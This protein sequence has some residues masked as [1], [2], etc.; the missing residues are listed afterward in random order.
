MKTNNFLLLALLI[1]LT[2]C[3][4]EESNPVSP[5]IT[6]Y[7]LTGHFEN[8][9]LGS[10]YKIIATDFLIL[11]VDSLWDPLHFSESE[12]NSDG[13]FTLH[14]GEITDS[15]RAEYSGYEVTNVNFGLMES[16][17]I[18]IVKDFA[19]R[20]FYLAYQTQIKYFA[21]YGNSPRRI[22]SDTAKAGDFGMGLEF[23]PKDYYINKT[24][25]FTNSSFTRTL[26]YDI[27]LKEGWNKYY[28]KLES[29]SSNSRVIK[30]TGTEPAGGKWYLTPSPN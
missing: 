12:V 17:T 11:S 2:G 28:I 4:K 6:T 1:I 9:T 21:Y 5:I 22:L 7:T 26:T 8:W 23:I 15:I 3:N 19:L 20:T 18:N 13:T 24:E 14:L 16:D 27:H 25:T 10:D 30:I 29:I